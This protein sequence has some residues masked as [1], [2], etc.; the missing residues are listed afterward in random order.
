MFW[1]CQGIR[2]KRKELQLYLTENSI[3]IIALNE[4]FLNKK[5]TFKVPGYDT[6]RKDRSTGVKG[7]VAFLVK[8][9]LV[10]NKEYRNE[11]FNIITDN[12]AL[13]INLELSNNQNLTLATI[14]CPNGNPSSSL[15]HTISNL[16]DNVMFIGDFNSKLESFGCAKKNTSGPMLKTIQ[17][18]LNLIY[19]NNDEH[20]HMDRA[21]GSTDILD[22]AFVSPNLAIHDIQFQI[23]DDLGSDHLPIEISIDTT[24]HRNTYTNHTKYKFDQT[25]REVFESTLEEAL[26]SADFS[27][28]MS[29]SDLDKYADFII[30][31]ISTA[32]DK[33][34]P[35]SKSVRPESTPIS[36]E[37][38][39]LIKE[40]RKLR[41]L[42][43][44]KK[45]PA[46][47]TRIN[48]LQKQVKEDLKLES[49]VSWE[50]FCNSISLE[51]DP[52]KSWR[53]IKNFL[54][55][56]G[57]RDYPTLH[58]ANKVA[59]TNADKAQLFAESVERHFGIESDHFDSNHFQDVNKF[60]EDNHRHFYPPEDPDDYRFDV[61]N[62]HELV[63]DVDA[64]TLIKLVK[65]LKRGKAPGPDT[66][67]NEV[68]RLGTTTS[69]FHHLAKLFTSSIQLGYIP[70]AWKIATL[71]ML[72]KP[73]KLPSLTTS[74]SPIS[75]ISSIM[76]LF[77][78]VIEQRLRSHLEHIGFI[79]KHQSGF[80][81]AKSTDDHLFRLSQSIMESF[82]KGEHV[83]AAFLDVEKAFDNVWHNGLRYKIFQLDLPTK[84][85][86]WLSDF[87]VGRLIQ[88]NVNN[89]FSN[90]INPKAGV[91]Q[92]SVLS[93]LLF[94]TYV[95]DLPAP[96][97]NQ[98]SLSQ[99]AD[100]TAQWA[101]SLSVR[102]AAKLL[103]QDLLNLAM[104]CAKWRIKLN[105]EKTKVIIF[106]RSILARKT[107]LNL[108]LYGETLKIYPQVKFLGIT[109]DSQLNFKK[110]FEDILD[111]C[112]TR[113]YRLRLLANKKWGPSPSTLIQI[114]KQCVQPI[115]EYGALSTI[116][117]SD[118]IISKI[119]RLQNKFIRLA[120]RLPKYI[121][122]KL[123]HDSTG[124]PYVKDRLLS[125]ATKSLDRIAQ[126]PLVEESI[127]HNRL[128]P[129]WDRFPTPLSVVRPGQP[130]A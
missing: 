101:F 85:T 84:M 120:L 111:R 115:F 102:I 49:L 53:K 5:Y 103:Q 62:E 51:S 44:Q 69:L 32:V 122:S 86:R 112:N 72:L 118:N 60:V 121:C 29:T 40:K 34:I 54:K 68:L 31:A 14:Y 77:E 36:D 35:T 104:W 124:L 95:N 19:L 73:D 88:V 59:K 71:R 80:R 70:T 38:R 91:P 119:Q 65:F 12:E 116:T 23:G 50:N 45:D 117:T 108:K 48:Q 4:T 89:F 81:R 6:I 110:H 79:N 63:A 107:E 57:Q 64:T 126:N 127:S 21:N 41:R 26:G 10:V 129:A 24:P 43:S 16:S 28:P 93:P 17:N 30:A 46:V 58:H 15:F 7:G 56:K 83:V 99:F 25:D 22:M 8:H 55:P 113:Y 100:D 37:T 90:Q 2:P 98:N 130:S 42:Y 47:K 39:A 106:S 9:G 82:N 74:Y 20:T 78:R 75:L 76:K 18:K 27:G 123:L 13:A 33:A 66:I 87:L 96:H 3:D 94:L 67:P 11:D 92:G 52:S 97:H 61:G 1:N 125:C 114:Y 105:P 128:N 109:F